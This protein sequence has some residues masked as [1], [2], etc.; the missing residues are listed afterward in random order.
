M[1]HVIDLNCDLG[2]TH[3]SLLSNYDADIMPYLSSCNIACGFHAGSE[4][5]IRKTLDLA[6]SNQVAIGAHPSYDDWENFGRVSINV[7]IAKL[8][9]QIIEQVELVKSI[10][11]SKGGRLHHVKPHGALYHDMAKNKQFAYELLEVIKRIDPT[12][13][14]YGLSGSEMII[15]AKELEL[16]YFEEGFADRAYDQATQLRSRNLD[17]A[18]LTEESD[19]I[20]QV[21]LLLSQKV[22]LKNGSQVPIS[23]DTICLHSDTEGATQLA[24]WIHQLITTKAN[25]DL[26]H[27]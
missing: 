14:I 21:N 12:L 23:V 20:D 3:P 16:S 15:A 19:V 7:P 4:D 5:Q 8:Q 2:E 9:Q 6:I 27:S 1:K 17:H 11:E 13:I 10:A 26:Y 24:K 25:V 18:V 22:K